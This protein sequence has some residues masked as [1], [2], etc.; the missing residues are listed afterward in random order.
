M[1]LDNSAP[2]LLAFHMP[3]SEIIRVSNNRAK[4]QLDHKV[5]INKDT[6]VII[7][8]IIFRVLPINNVA[9]D[10]E[11][12]EVLRRFGATRGQQVAGYSY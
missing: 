9:Y 4:D 8:L 2:N 7:N 6:E 3:L 5:A 1:L 12:Q 11:E 10:K